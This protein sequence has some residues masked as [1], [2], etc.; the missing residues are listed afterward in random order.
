MSTEKISI[1]D[2]PQDVVVKYLV[3]KRWSYHDLADNE[4]FQGEPRQGSVYRAAYNTK[5]NSYR[6][7]LNENPINA[8]LI[9]SLI[10]TESQQ[11]SYELA[12]LTKYNILDFD[13]KESELDKIINW[14]H[15]NNTDLYPTDLPQ[16]NLVVINFQAALAQHQHEEAERFAWMTEEMDNLDQVN[17]LHFEILVELAAYLTEFNLLRHEDPLDLALDEDMGKG[18]NVSRAQSYLKKYVGKDRK[19]NDE[20]EDIITAIYHL[21]TE[22]E[23]RDLNEQ[24]V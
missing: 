4:K 21:I 12:E 10:S 6:L 13:L 15:K 18:V 23:R 17:S 16:D 22:L 11:G 9:D 2:N 1:R 7:I 19:T 3:C 8:L 5:T 24:D 20:R 14:K